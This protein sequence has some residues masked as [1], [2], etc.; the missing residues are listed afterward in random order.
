MS[1]SIW[2][3]PDQKPDQ[4]Q[5]I[6]FFAG[7]SNFPYLG[8]YYK[9]FDTFQDWESKHVQKWCDID[10]LIAQADKAERLQKAVDLAIDTLEVLKNSTS[11]TE[12]YLRTTCIENTIFVIKQL[13]KE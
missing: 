3:M 10:D 8:F 12:D 9:R 5:Q 7:G 13:I 2:K 1:N 4:D 6:L 11:R